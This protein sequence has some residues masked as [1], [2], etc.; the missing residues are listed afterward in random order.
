MYSLN[1]FRL[2]FGLELGNE[3]TSEIVKRNVR[4]SLRTKKQIRNAWN[5]EYRS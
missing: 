3:W 1:H 4:G 5:G 2:L